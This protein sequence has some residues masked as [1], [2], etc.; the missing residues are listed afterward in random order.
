MNEFISL[1]GGVRVRSDGL[2]LLPHRA[3]FYEVKGHQLTATQLEMSAKKPRYYT[4]GTLDDL[5]DFQ[6]RELRAKQEGRYPEPTGAEQEERRLKALTIAANRAKTN[7]RKWCK[8]INAD[9]LLTLTYKGNQTDL[10][11][12]KKHLREFVRRMYR[13]CPEFRGVAGFEP[14]ERGAWH[15]H[16]GCPRTALVVQGDKSIKVKSYN[17]IRAIWRSVTGEWGGNI[18]VQRRKRNSQ[19][20]PARIA[21]YLSKYMLKSFDEVEAGTNRW[22]RFGP[23]EMPRVLD[24]GIVW[25]TADMLSNCFGL[26]G[27][28][29][30]IVTARYSHF[31][32]WFYLAAESP[33]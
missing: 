11:L 8:V 20:S 6:R 18:D 13:I 2:V 21:A 14:Q 3:E 31:G 26:V 19:R 32:D 25:D 30:D 29:T 7:V 4:E 27:D 16:M 22:T 33:A 23:M 15:V 10:Q 5:T 17:V 9:S 1:T 24:L 12:C 28:N